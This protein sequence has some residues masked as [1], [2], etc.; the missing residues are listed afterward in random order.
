MLRIRLQ[1]PKSEPLQQ[2]DHYD[3]IHDA[4]INAWI[5]AGADSS[6]VIGHHAKPWTFASLGWHHGHIGVAHGL[7]ISTVD[8]GLARTL[9]RLDPAQVTKRRWDAASINF[10][11]AS[12]RIEPDPI[13]P[14]QTQLGCLMLSPL[15][16][17]DENHTGKG[18]RWYQN[19]SALGAN[20]S[21]IIN[22]KLSFMAGRD[23][24][25]RISPDFLYL[26]ANPQHSVL[27]SLK[28]FKDGRKNFVIGMQAP[29]L[30]EGSED[31]L[32]MAWYAGIGQ[33][34]RSGFGCL[35]LLEQ[36]VGR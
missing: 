35:G 19:L 22:R 36:G 26:R 34:T 25:L 6:E 23:V 21:S 20:L 13:L 3:L 14:Q 32:R 29:L 8:A 16:L 18:K 7:V 2:Y 9:S 33:K 11:A 28:S 10:A 24:Q 4:L 15:V 30:L 31:D 27:V 5:A 1:L 12:V 17:H